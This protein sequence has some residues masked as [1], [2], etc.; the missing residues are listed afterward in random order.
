MSTDYK[1][2]IPN[3]RRDGAGDWRTRNVAHCDPH[4]WLYSP[5]SHH[6]KRWSAAG[7]AAIEHDNCSAILQICDGTTFYLGLVIPLRP[8]LYPRESDA[9]NFDDKIR[10]VVVHHYFATTILY[11]LCIFTIKSL[12]VSVSVVCIVQD[13]DICITIS[14]AQ[15]FINERVIHFLL[16]PLIH[17]IS[18]SSDI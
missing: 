2:Y 5:K 7:V 11:L 13:P 18:W 12:V 16:P 10:V 9:S 15:V 8:V 4:T 3:V 17:P 1:I 14:C 6:I